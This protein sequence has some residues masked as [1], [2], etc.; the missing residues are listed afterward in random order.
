MVSFLLEAGAPPDSG[1]LQ[2]AVDTA[3][4]AMADVLLAAGAS[5]DGVRLHKSA[6]V[7]EHAAAGDVDALRAEF[8]AFADPDWCA[9]D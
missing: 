4:R 2:L 9:A 8:E 5:R 1:L 7:A 3:D 6:A